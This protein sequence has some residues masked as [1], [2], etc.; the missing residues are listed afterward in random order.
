[1][2]HG[3]LHEEETITETEHGNETESKVSMTVLAMFQTCSS[4]WSYAIEDKGA[5]SVD[6]VARR[7][8]D[9]IETVG[10]SKERI[11]SKTDH[12]RSIVQS[13]KEVATSRKDEGTPLRIYE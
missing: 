11:I 7:V 8:V 3:F 12:E 10:L 1:M 13:Q 6:W 2:H 5:V 4:I 9:D